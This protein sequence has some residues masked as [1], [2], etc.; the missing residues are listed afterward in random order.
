[1]TRGPD[2]Q[3]PSGSP[4]ALPFSDRVFSVTRQEV[5]GVPYLL[6]VAGKRANE[7]FTFRLVL[8]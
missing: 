1:M 2:P 6:V 5:D 4:R 8:N 3:R 7:G